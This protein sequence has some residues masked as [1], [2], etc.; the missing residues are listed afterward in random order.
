[1][2]HLKRIC[3]VSAVFGLL[4]GA[5]LFAHDAH[6]LRLTLKRVVFEGSKRTEVLTIV[7]DSPDDMVYRLGWNNMVMG[8]D[9]Q[10]LTPVGAGETIPGLNTADD[11]VIFAPRR[12]AIP[13]GASQQVRLML[14]K[15]AD[16][17]DGEYRSHLWVRPEEDAA[18]FQSPAT[19]PAADKP[20][21]QIKMLAGISFPVFVRHGQLTASGSITNPRATANGNRITITFDLNR[22]GNRSLYGDLEVT[23]LSG[24]NDM[25]PVHQLRGVAVYTEI[26]TRPVDFTFTAPEGTINACKSMRLAYVA[27]AKDPLF[28]GKAIA[29]TTLTLP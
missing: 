1:M 4:A 12:I 8:T 10:T 19:E 5:M 14:R 17:A 13:A 9:S 22:E 28:S 6:A 7:N 25:P 23:C 18:K 29:E 27:D 2:L 15:P 3:A 24:G 26:T 16:L 11:L 20:A 21:V